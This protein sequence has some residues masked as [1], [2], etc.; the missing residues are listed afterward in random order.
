MCMGVTA[1]AYILTMFAVRFLAL[2]KLLTLSM[3]LWDSDL[4]DAS[5]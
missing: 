2:I 1:G 3:I 4:F 5:F